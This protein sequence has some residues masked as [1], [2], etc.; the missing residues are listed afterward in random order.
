MIRMVRRNNGSQWQSWCLYAAFFVA[1]TGASYAVLSLAGHAAVV[2]GT[3]GMLNVTNVASVFNLVGYSYFNN[4]GYIVMGD[5]KRGNIPNSGTGKLYGFSSIDVVG[6]SSLGG[7]MTAFIFSDSALPS[8]EFQNGSIISSVYTF[9]S[10]ST[11]QPLQNE[12]YKGVTIRLYRTITTLASY[13]YSNPNPI[14]YSEYGTVFVF[15]NALF[16]CYD[17]SPELCNA[18]SEYLI[19]LLSGP[20]S[21]L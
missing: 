19:N 4:L 8:A 20:A 13:N 15:K 11:I 7:T 14:T 17:S 2:Y 16:F 18:T 6:D 10:N 5:V 9:E 3:Q 21:K 12:T 1:G